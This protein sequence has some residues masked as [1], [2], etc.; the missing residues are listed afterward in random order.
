MPGNNKIHNYKFRVAYSDTDQMGVMHHSNYLR[1][2]EMARY[3]LLRDMG[4]SYSEIENDGVIMPVI[5]ANVDYK[6]PAVY[7]QKIRIETRIALNKGPRIVFAADMF[8]EAGEIIC[9]S[10]ITLAFVNKVNR[11]AC[12]PPAIIKSKLLT[13]KN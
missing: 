5:Q 1:Y 3:E 12:F 4:I 13:L 11:K 7:D 6:K 10:E 9:K 2:F 8:D